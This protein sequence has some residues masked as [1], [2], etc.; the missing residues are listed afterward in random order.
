MSKF[1]NYMKELIKCY[2]ITIPLTIFFILFIPYN[3][4][5]YIIYLFFIVLLGIFYIEIY[6]TLFKFF[7]I[8]LKYIKRK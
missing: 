2:L 7:D 4:T 5:T 3:A 1:K 8:C 6:S